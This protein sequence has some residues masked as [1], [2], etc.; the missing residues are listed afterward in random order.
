M[1]ELTAKLGTMPTHRLQ[2]IYNHASRN[3]HNGIDAEAAHY[4]M[5]AIE[6]VVDLRGVKITGRGGSWEFVPR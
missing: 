2:A 5:T 1:S 6:F 4:V 3:R